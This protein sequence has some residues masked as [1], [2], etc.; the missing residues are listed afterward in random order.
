MADWS[1]AEEGEGGGKGNDNSDNH[2]SSSFPPK[3]CLIFLAENDSIVQVQ[4]IRRQ[5]LPHADR[6]SVWYEHGYPHGA[7]LLDPG[8]GE[9]VCEQLYRMSTAGRGVERDME[10]VNRSRDVTEVEGGT[11]GRKSVEK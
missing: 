2:T 10:G 3:R 8:I 1:A 7:M 5:L 4:S 6:L 9:R 11:S